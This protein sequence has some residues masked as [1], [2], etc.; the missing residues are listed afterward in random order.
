MAAPLLSLL[1]PVYNTSKSLVACLNSILQKPFD[2]ME[3]ICVDDGSTDNS[4]EILR[5]YEKCDKRI[6]IISHPENSGLLK[7]RRTGVE[8]ASGRY[9]MFIDSDDT[10]D[11][12]LCRKAVELIQ[13]HNTDIVQ[14][15][16]RV[17]YLKKGKTD[18]IEPLTE[19]FSG[20]QVLENHF[21][22][23]NISTSLVVKIYN[24]E[25]CKQ[26]FKEIP[27]IRCYV[28]EDV[29]TSFFIAYFTSSYVGV[30]TKVK[31]NYYFGKGISE[32]DGITLEKYKLYCEM[33]R[34]PEI[35]KAFLDRKSAEESDY[36]ALAYMTNRLV[37]D[38]C[39]NFAMMQEN[40]K[41]EAWDLFWKSWSENQFFSK[42]MMF[43]INTI[44]EIKDSES[45]KIG[46]AIVSPLH[47]IRNALGMKF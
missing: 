46:N 35:V 27:D 4:L 13:H 2:D 20:K 10:I 29:L 28:G 23:M 30:K 26:A 45:Y 7:A 8:H 42:A 37:N 14:F 25:I 1:I 16:A 33:N 34:F 41:D 3:I 38:C 31:Y 12:G 11:P 18:F 9:I 22:F 5:K 21:V 17:R 43:T 24:A 6:K 19:K 44:R 32:E 36:N 15:S 40:E 47:N 39:N